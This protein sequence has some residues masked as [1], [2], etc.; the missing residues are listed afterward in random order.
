[1]AGEI[2]NTLKL[3]VNQ[4]DQA[5]QKASD[6]LDKLDSNLGKPTLPSKAWRRFLVV[7]AEIFASSLPHSKRLMTIWQLP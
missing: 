2:N 6:R 5:I 4:F 7:W 1:M 3:D